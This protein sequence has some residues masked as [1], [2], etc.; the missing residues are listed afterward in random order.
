MDVL[1]YSVIVMVGDKQKQKKLNPFT[2]KWAGE[3]CTITK[4]V[5]RHF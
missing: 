5:I 4:Y 1:G 2:I 3:I